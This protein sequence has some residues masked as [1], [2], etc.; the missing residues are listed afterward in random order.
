[1]RVVKLGGSLA[2][3]ERLPQCLSRLACPGVIVVP[4]G[5]PFANQVRAAQQRWQFDDATA[6]DMALLAM[7]QFGRM[8]AGLERRFRLAG[9][10]AD[11]QTH[12]A[13]GLPAVW[14]PRLADIEG[15]GVAASWDV[16]SDSLSA[17]LA[18]RLAATD[19]ILVKSVRCTPGE[20]TLEHLVD[21]G[22][23]DRSF[24]HFAAAAP[25]P[26][27]LCDREVSDALTA[28]R[29]TERNGLLRIRR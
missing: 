15:S 1:M 10:L 21:N 16:T 7:G 9:S 11:L 8:L 23:V 28:D 4:G 2:D 22:I 13:K 5:G 12:A 19:L 3:W 14:L 24:T 18:T 26:I 20:A 29:L 27:W 25:C 6:H 17:W